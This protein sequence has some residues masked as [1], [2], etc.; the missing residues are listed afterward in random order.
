[1][2]EVPSEAAWERPGATWTERGCV[3][4]KQITMEEHAW[5]RSRA[6]WTEEGKLGKDLGQ[7]PFTE[8]GKERSML[9][10]DSTRMSS[11]MTHCVEV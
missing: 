3:S 7:Q 5:K 2:L 9:G 1:M 4:V 10:I 8:E 6:T 11:G